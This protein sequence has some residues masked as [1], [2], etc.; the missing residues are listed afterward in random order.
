VTSRTVALLH[1]PLTGAAAWGRLPNL[2]RASGTEAVVVS[3]VEDDA[4]P[5]AA[6]FVASAARQVAALAPDPGDAV[7][8][9][10]HSGAGALLPQVGYARRAAHLPVGGYVFLDASLPRG[11]VPVSRLGAMEA[12]E[13]AFAA[14]LSA[15]L[16]AGGRYPTWTEDD[17][18]ADAPDVAERRGL[19]ASLRP[20]GLDYFSEQLP[21]LPANPDWPDAPCGVLRTSPGYELAAR[22]ADGRGWPVVRRDLGHFAALADPAA[23]CVALV[24]LIARL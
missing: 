2:L 17:L 14:E 9:V 16:A 15:A 24:E 20:R 4:A 11:G 18:R 8:L 1:S 13:P 7:L 21:A 12:D 10:G 5:Y 23:T 22:L 3:V 19:L 6:R